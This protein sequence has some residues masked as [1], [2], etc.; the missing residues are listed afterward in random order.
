M[1]LT[2]MSSVSGS[3]VNSSPAKSDL[4][5]LQINIHKRKKNSMYSSK[6]GT[7]YHAWANVLEPI[8]STIFGIKSFL[9]RKLVEMLRNSKCKQSKN[10]R[11]IFLF[12]KKVNDQMSKQFSWISAGLFWNL[13]YSKQWSIWHRDFF[14]FPLVQFRKMY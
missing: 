1:E 10:T 11:I 4:F 8:L 14:L 13:N 12:L 9:F 6:K 5:I 2:H 7:T 3:H